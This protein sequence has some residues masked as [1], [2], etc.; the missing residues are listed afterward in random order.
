MIHV[1]YK[2]LLSE[3]DVD[4]L[5]ANWA[6]ACGTLELFSARFSEESWAYFWR[7]LSTEN[8]SRALANS[9]KVERA[10]IGI[11]K[12]CPEH[13]SAICRNTWLIEWL[14]HGV[15]YFGD[16]I[17]DIAF[18]GTIQARRI[19]TSIAGTAMAYFRPH[20]NPLIG[21]T[22]PLDARQSVILEALLRSS[23]NPNQHY[24]LARTYAH[25]LLQPRTSAARAHDTE[26]SL[27]EL[28]A[29]GI[30]HQ[31]II[32][33]LLQANNGLQQRHGQTE[34]QLIELT[35]RVRQVEEELRRRKQWERRQKSRNRSLAEQVESLNRRLRDVEHSDDDDS[36]D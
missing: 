16:V 25:T 22:P 33:L 28:R 11:Q 17:Q 20:D 27:V 5:L 10:R 29:L 34:W 12:L 7:S 32:N 36:S 2:P 35:R 1:S 13:I 4:D 6:T 15:H 31:V 3:Q 21:Q 18:G 26:T 30:D 24:E 19:L 23:H 8:G 14:D 9:I